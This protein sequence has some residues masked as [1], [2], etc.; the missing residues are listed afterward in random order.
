MGWVRI[1]LVFLFVVVVTAMFALVP[2]QVPALSTPATLAAD[3]SF[4]ALQ[5]SARTIRPAFP[6]QYLGVAWRTGHAPT[7]RFET[8]GRWGRWRA[9]HLETDQPGKDGLHHS[10]LIPGYSAEAYQLRGLAR[11]VKAVA[12]NAID[13]PRHVV[14]RTPARAAAQAS[15]SE[16]PI[17]SRAQWGANESY[18]FDS[19]GAEVWPPAFYPTQKLTVHHTAGQ[20]NDPN[21]AAT[22]RSIYY[23]HAVTLG[24]GDIGYQFLIDAQ[25][26]IYKGRWSG[27]ANDSNSAD[28]SP[29]GENA[30]GYGVTAAH[31]KDYNSGNIGVAILGT[32][33]TVDISPA[34]RSSL[35]NLLAWEADH[36]GLDPQASSTYTNPITGVQKFEPNISGHRDWAATDCPGTMLYADL[37]SIRQD[38]ATA[39]AGP[40]PTPTPTPTGTTPPPPITTTYAPGSVTV[41]KGTAV[42]DPVSNLATDDGVYYRVTAAKVKKT[43]YVANWYGQ[44]T[45]SGT[46]SKLT[47]NYD[48]ASSISTNQ[49]LYVYNFSTSSWQQVASGTGT[50]TDATATWSTTS[51]SAYLSSTGAIRLRVYQTGGQA[52]QS[53]GDLISFTV[54]S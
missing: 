26:N 50:A 37:P 45:A 14:W 49:T 34:A 8:H 6:V 7:V 12:I 43:K 53:R 9:V 31:V 4:G 23:Y 16:P 27:P 25:G 48:G 44:A 46:A 11:G 17:V 5:G 2:V 32:Y 36:H 38:V 33:D 51:P 21:P 20:N 19:T 24:Y 30:Q 3:R 42:G 35:V 13:G 28:D 39:I 52:F 47:V 54:Q 41:L 40:S 1:F 18:R 15:L 29:T 22:V 10:D